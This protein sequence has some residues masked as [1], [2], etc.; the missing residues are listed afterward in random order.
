MANREGDE[1]HHFSTIS[2]GPACF[3]SCTSKIG[4]RK[5]RRKVTLNWYP[6]HAAAEPQELQFALPQ[7]SQRGWTASI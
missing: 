6:A 3:T 1:A 5:Y 4:A 2:C 7:R